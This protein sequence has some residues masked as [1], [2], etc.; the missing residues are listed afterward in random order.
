MMEFKWIRT[1]VSVEGRSSVLEHMWKADPGFHFTG[2]NDFH[3]GS[4]GAGQFPSKQAMS[5]QAQAQD[6]GGSE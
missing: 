3:S 2:F 6:F 1:S 4:S 5:D